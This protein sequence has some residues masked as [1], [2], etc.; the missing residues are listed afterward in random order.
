MNVC[1]C[2]IPIQADRLLSNQLLVVMDCFVKWVPEVLGARKE[3]VVAMG[4][5]EK[6]GSWFSCRVSSNPYPRYSAAFASSGIPLPHGH[7]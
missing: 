2:M 4:W 5:T 6:P 7:R 3:A 1:A